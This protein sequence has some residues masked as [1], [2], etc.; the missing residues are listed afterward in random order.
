MILGSITGVIFSL[1]AIAGTFHLLNQR[2][3]ASTVAF[4]NATCRYDHC[5]YCV[6]NQDCGFCAMSSELANTYVSGTCSAAHEAATHSFGYY[7]HGNL[8]L[9]CNGSTPIAHNGSNS[10][11]YLAWFDSSCP[12]DPVAFLAVGSLFL[13]L[14]FF[15]PG[16][17][18]VPWAINS[19]IYPTWARSFGMAASTTT[20]WVCNLLVSLTFLSLLDAVTP[21]LGYIV[22]AVLASLG[23]IFIFLTVPETKGLK[24]EDIEE[25]FK[26]PYFVTFC[27]KR[28]WLARRHF[29][30]YSVLQERG[31]HSVANGPEDAKSHHL[32][33]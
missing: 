3:A 2:S 16:I 31:S 12:P 4:P 24:L 1:L 18:A 33:L 13:Y 28:Q 29:F 10:S 20:N 8:T 17:G 11:D 9:V 27:S 15:A 32:N 30:T 22:I 6:A 5:L 7:S 23:L 21:A 25:L 26:K 14:A 19:E